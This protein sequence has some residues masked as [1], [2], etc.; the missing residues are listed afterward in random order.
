MFDSTFG[1]VAGLVVGLVFTITVLV[2]GVSIG[3]FELGQKSAV[4]LS[5]IESDPMNGTS[6]VPEMQAGSSSVNI[7]K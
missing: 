1:K 6:K 3:G 2:N 5:T 4:Q 7:V